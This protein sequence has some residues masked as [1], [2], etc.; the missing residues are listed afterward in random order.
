MVVLAFWVA[1]P[2]PSALAAL[3]ATDAVAHR[4]GDPRERVNRF[5]AREDVRATLEAQGVDPAEAQ[6][7]VAGL[8]DSEIAQI[9]DQVDK[10]PAGGVIGLVIGVLIIVL[11]V[12]LILK[13]AGK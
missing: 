7:R 13:V 10:L 1:L 3:V 12:V 11:L 9:A 5:L 4:E 6:A 8:T 2:H